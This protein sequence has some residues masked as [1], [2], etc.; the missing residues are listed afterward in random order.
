MAW[1]G[2]MPLVHLQWGQ[3]SKQVKMVTF[4]SSR[5]GPSMRYWPSTKLTRLSG[6]LPRPRMGSSSFE[7]T[8]A[9][10]RLVPL[11]QAARQ[12]QA[13]GNRIPLNI[14]LKCEVILSQLFSPLHSP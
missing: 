13:R 10:T 12:K 14:F 8:R 6:R 7:E 1:S 5:Q 3:P 2:T 9:C 4:S 11:Q